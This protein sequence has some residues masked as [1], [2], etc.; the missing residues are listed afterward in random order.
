V[1]RPNASKHTVNELAKQTREQDVSS[2]KASEQGSATTSEKGGG[3][4]LSRK[5][6]ILLRLMVAGSAVVVGAWIV[7][8][9][10]PTWWEQAKVRVSSIVS[11]GEK[12][13]LQP[14]V[15]PVFK[16]V[17]P[18]RVNPLPPSTPMQQGSIP[19]GVEQSPIATP[20]TST[21]PAARP[22]VV[23]PAPV[24]GRVEQSPYAISPSSLSAKKE[25][26]ELDDYMEIGSL[27]AQKGDYQKAEGLF[28]KVA[29][30]N[31]S[32]ARSRNN[33]GFVYL[34]QQK[35]DLAEREF[36]EAIRLDPAFTLPYYN[37]ACLYTRKGI[38]VDALI[39]L[40]RA[41][42]RDARVKTWAAEDEDLAKLKSDAV[43][44]DLIG[45][46]AAKQQKS[47]KQEGVK[48]QEV[49]KQGTQQ[50][51]VATQRAGILKMPE[52]QRIVAV[53]P[54]GILKMPE[55]PKLDAIVKQG[56]IQQ[57]PV[58]PKKS[59]IPPKEGPLRRSKQVP[60]GAAQQGKAGA[61]ANPIK[62][63]VNGQGDIVQ[64][65]PS[66]PGTTPIQGTRPGATPKQD[67]KQEVTPKQNKEG[68]AP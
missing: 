16:V 22:Q 60:P 67:T 26:A 37:L 31:P 14:P 4:T 33:L 65:Q 55:L 38:D 7:F 13:T 21:S 15:K 58:S 59:V 44:Q 18:Q 12:P 6:K 49:Q 5:K 64:N 57:Q 43:F 24:S 1:K 39:Y 2:L 35:Y 34:K 42:N 45:I 40:K 10:K 28:Q 30:E 19:A 20:P 47:A 32:S 3:G 56:S 23:V 27:Y 41:L 36:K 8:T 66:A 25:N 68:N 48:R 54:A 63:N 17:E 62:T 50:G 29:K 51:S 46:P 53:Q 61:Q 11:P 52:L 9:I